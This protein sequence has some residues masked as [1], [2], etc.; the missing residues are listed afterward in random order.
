[1]LDTTNLAGRV[2]LDGVWFSYPTA[3]DAGAGAAPT[4]SDNAPDA[5]APAQIA[6]APVNALADISFTVEPGQLAAI[7]GPSGSDKTTL[8][9]L[10]PRLY[11]GST[12]STAAGS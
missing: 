4:G 10:I 7:V 6:S 2:E 5:A 8:S 1:V 9:Y 11:E 3:T 12:T